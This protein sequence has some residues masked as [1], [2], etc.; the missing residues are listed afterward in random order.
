VHYHDGH[1]PSSNDELLGF[2]ASPT[3]SDGNLSANKSSGNCS[4]ENYHLDSFHIPNKRKVGNVGHKSPENDALVK[5]GVS[6]DLDAIFNDDVIMDSFVKTFETNHG[7]SIHGTNDAFKFKNLPSTPVEICTGYRTVLGNHTANCA[8]ENCTSNCTGLGSVLYKKIGIQTS[9]QLSRI[10]NSDF[11][12]T[13]FSTFSTGNA[14]KNLIMDQC[15]MADYIDA[16]SK[17]DSRK[18]KRNC[19]SDSPQNRNLTP[20]TIMVADSIGAVR[21]RRLLKVL[22]DSGSGS[23]TTLS[24]RSAY[25]KS[26]DHAKYIRVEW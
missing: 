3:L 9:K 15:Y 25:L 19:I 16:K 5:T 17:I 4:P 7:L 24:I 1:C 23:T 21:S 14:P 13:N 20:V 2:C 8:L 10:T 18:R 6:P 22:L 26:V 12:G 11:N